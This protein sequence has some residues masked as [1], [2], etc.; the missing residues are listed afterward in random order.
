VNFIIKIIRPMESHEY[1][2]Q[3][4]ELQTPSGSMIIQYG[5]VP[6]ITL[7]PA[8]SINMYTAARVFEAVAMQGGLA[9]IERDSVTIICHE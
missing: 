3:W 4:I 1:N 2:V 9:K 8:Q 5:H 6:Y 7:L